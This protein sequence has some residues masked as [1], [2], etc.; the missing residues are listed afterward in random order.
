M[1]TTLKVLGLALGMTAVSVAHGTNPVAPAVLPGRGLAQHDFF[2]AGEAKEERL[3]IVRDGK[4]T[5]AYRHPGKGE[6]SDAC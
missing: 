1:N 5:W 3:F 6:I 2:Y 4:V